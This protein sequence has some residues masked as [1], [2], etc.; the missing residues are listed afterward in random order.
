MDVDLC[1]D[2]EN[3]MFYVYQG[4]TLV[5]RTKSYNRALKRFNDL[6]DLYGG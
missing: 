4:A 3:R 1:F 2:Y 5:L 6:C